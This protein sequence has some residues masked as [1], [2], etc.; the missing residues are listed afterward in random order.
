[1]AAIRDDPAAPA[2][3][4]DD[5]A[6]TLVVFTDYQC[7]AC[8]AAHPAMMRATQAAGDVRILFRDVP[9]FGPKSVQAA[10]LALAMQAQGRY[11]AMHDALM[12]ERRPLDEAVLRDLVTSTGG[13]WN[14]ARQAA[15]GDPRVTA[16]LSRNAADA[17]QLGVTGT[18]TY[19]IG[20]Y[21]IVGALSEREFT[22]AFAQARNAAGAS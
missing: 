6:V 14:L 1:M 16:Q 20:P 11:L 13:N 9:V 19:L 10:R 2:F 5:A 7:P 4:P 3:G 22:K 15:T 21:R 18:P 8:R 12:R 17:L